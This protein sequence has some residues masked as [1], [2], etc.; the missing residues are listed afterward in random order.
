[1]II[2]SGGIWRIRRVGEGRENSVIIKT[3]IKN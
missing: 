3:E 1:L 2:K